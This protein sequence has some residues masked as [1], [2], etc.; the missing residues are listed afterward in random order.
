[1]ELHNINKQAY[2]TLLEESFPG[3]G[4]IID[5]Y[6]NCGFSWGSGRLFFKEEYGVPLSHVSYFER[7]VLIE[8][9][10]YAL[11]A[12]HA[13]CTKATHRKKGF[14]S[15]L[16]KEALLWA[17]KRSDFVILFSDLLQFYSKLSF[18]PIQEN[19]FYLPCSHVNGKLT[20]RLV[21]VPK[22]NDLVL[23]CFLEREPL[24]NVF[25]IEDRGEISTFQML[26][27][28]CYP[29]NCSLYYSPLIDGL[30]AYYLEGKTLHLLD[31]IAKTL[32]TLDLILDHISE[33]IEGV[34]F[35][36]SPDKFTHLAIPQ[37]YVYDDI[38]I[39]THGAFPCTKPFMVSPLSRC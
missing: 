25:W 15:S 39:M 20:S 2:F 16:I 6:E 26:L 21:K 30:I 17:E 36:F 13:I 12:I 10:W 7:P 1:M 33:E 35:Y 5:R 34:Y 31:V 24:S 27:S 14:A 32:P 22:D 23:R 11:G 28:T 37:P 9:K 8:G 38:Y 29:I 4:N 18:Q 19:R 3:L